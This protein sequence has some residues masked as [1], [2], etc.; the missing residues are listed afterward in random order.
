VDLF[1]LPADYAAIDSIVRR[2]GLFVLAD[3][4]QSYGAALGNRRVG[5]LA[6]M[7]AVSFFPAKPLGCYGDGGAILT[8]SADDAK[9]L[10]SIRMHGEGDDRYDIV[11]LGTNG[12]LD[13]LQAAVLLAKLEVFQDELDARERWASEYDRRLKGR[14]V[15]PPRRKDA[16]SAWAQYCV[17]VPRRDAVR[18]KLTQQGIPTAVYY[19]KPLHVQ[20]AFARFAH[21]LSLPV[22]EKICGQIM[23]LPMHPYLDEA[24][25]ECIAQA[26]LQ[27][28]G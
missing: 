26:L 9:I 22:S 18:E 23:A 27:A 13:T 15:L 3:A 11:R 5:T 20:P 17:R 21:G 6:P 14:L 1:G 25:V 8:D 12:R 4:A 7:T 24:T 16:T 2:H 19:P 10:R 28:C